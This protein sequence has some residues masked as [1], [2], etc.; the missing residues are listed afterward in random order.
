MESIHSM[1]DF[2]II[3]A[4]DSYKMSHYTMLPKGI[5]YMGSYFESR[6]GAEL[7]NTVFFGLQYLMEKYF[8]GKVVT[9]KKI[10]KAEKLCEWHFQRDDIF[11]REG[12]EYILNDCNGKLPVSIK[13]V[14][15][16][17]Q[18]PVGNVLYTIENTDPKVAWLTNHL[19]TLLVQLWYPCTIA[20]ISYYQKKILLNALKKTGTM[21]NVS[22]MLHDFGFRGST[23]RESAGIGGAAH[24]I[25][26][27]GSDNIAGME[28]INS[29]YYGETPA[30]SVPA[31]EHSTITSWGKEHEIDAYR[32]ILERFKSGIVSVVSDSWDVFNACEKLWG[33]KLHDKIRDSSRVLVIRPD[34][35]DPAYVID[36][37]L[38]IL[39]NKFGYS[40]NSKGYKLLPRYIRILQGDGIRWYDFELL[41]DKIIEKK[42]SLDNLIF[43]SGGGLLQD[44]NRDTQKFALKCSWCIIEEN[45]KD[46]FRPVYKQPA[47]DSGKNSKSG[48]LKLVV[49]DELKQYKTVDDSDPRPNMLRESIFK[50]KNC[51]EKP[52][53][54]KLR[55][56]LPNTSFIL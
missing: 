17:T 53:L 31:S 26:F 33:E 38:S 48:K 35:G 44:C 9:Q 11:N 39:S 28:M 52:H 56:R 23:S 8:V 22:H 2:N 7:R 15:E 4:T 37:C 41:I 14:P 34:S 36:K 55:K 54:M 3:T 5:K 42:W 10:D 21:S 46:I 40:I 19:E 30:F 25:N 27:E 16:G 29:Y 50:W 6:V 43:G 32:N 24:L 51:K 1:N 49:N 45:G 12:W 20:T 18:I 47:T 13:A